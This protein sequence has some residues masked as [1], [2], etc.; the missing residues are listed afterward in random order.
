VR[1]R[2]GAFGEGAPRRD[3]LLSPDHAVFCDSV[4]IPIKYLANGAT[5]MQ[6]RVASAHYFH[7]EL[8]SHDV[9]LAEGLSVESYLDTGNR[10]AFAN[11]GTEMMLH[12]DF[13]ALGWEDAC[14][15]L[16]LDGPVVTAVRRRLAERQTKMS[17]LR[18]EVGGRPIH[19]AV[20]KG[21]RY[22][23]LLP[24]GTRELRILSHSVEAALGIAENAHRFGVCI[25]GLVA[26]GR[27]IALDGAHLGCG[28]H[29]VAADGTRWT[30]GTAEVSLPKLT[31]PIA[32][33]IL[34][35]QTLLEAGNRTTRYAIA[36]SA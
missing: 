6:E 1:V 34:L 31:G 25:G 29:P 11:G 18:V 23:F 10:R 26:N 8:E 36:A 12:P 30:D 3:L 32:L 22:C 17:G 27:T 21:S 9:I 33:E 14:A 28:F 19:P 5:V 7:V 4:L 35:L 13:S 16:C 15:P 2:A 20:V 24:A